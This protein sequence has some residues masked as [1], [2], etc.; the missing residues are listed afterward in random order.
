MSKKELWEHVKPVIVRYANDSGNDTIVV[1][2]VEQL[3]VDISC[4][5][6]NGD[7]FRYP[8]SY[9]LEYRFDNKTIDLKN[10][11]EYMKALT[12][13]LEDCHSM[14]DAITEYQDETKAEYEREMCANMD[15]D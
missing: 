5:D 10:V 8:T 1:D 3:I 12:N 15:W 9:S 14:L 11:Y 4:L 7:N 13:F 6:K 2:I